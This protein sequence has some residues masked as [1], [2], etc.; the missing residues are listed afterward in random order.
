MDRQKYYQRRKIESNYLA[1][2][3]LES[4]RKEL[5]I[6][7]LEKEDTEEKF[8]IFQVRSTQFSVDQ[9]MFFE[10]IYSNKNLRKRL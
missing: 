10:K 9:K 8:E 7:V 3:E 4:L 2:Q 5:H 6:A 1:Q